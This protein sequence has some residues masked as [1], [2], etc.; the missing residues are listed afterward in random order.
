VRTASVSE[1]LAHTERQ[2]AI[3]NNRIVPQHNGYSGAV[4][5]RSSAEGSTAT[6]LIPLIVE[7][8]ARL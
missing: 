3:K 8:A 6:R 5:D 7:F 2:R 1:R 4:W